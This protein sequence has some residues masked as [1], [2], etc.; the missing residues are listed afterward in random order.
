MGRGAGGT[1]GRLGAQ[2]GL[3]L[4]PT[5]GEFREIGK[6][7][8]AVASDIHGKGLWREPGG[9]AFLY[10][11]SAK[12]VAIGIYH[13]NALNEY[14]KCGFPVTPNSYEAL[15]RATYAPDS[16]LTV[17]GHL[18][19]SVAGRA[20]SNR[21][22]LDRSFQ[23]MQVARDLGTPTGTRVNIYTDDEVVTA[24]I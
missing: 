20:L 21:E 18:I 4:S 19:R 12:Q 11:P 17:F 7:S 10:N 13:A 5:R 9:A 23:F 6:Y 15:T 2:T 14:V 22:Q 16:G 3:D 8:V 1:R 24:A